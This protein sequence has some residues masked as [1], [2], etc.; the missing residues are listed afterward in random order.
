[1]RRLMLSLLL[2][3]LIEE[4]P[5]MDKLWV[6]F[7]ASYAMMGSANTSIAAPLSLAPAAMPAIFTVD[8]RYQSYNV[9]MAEVVGGNFWKPYDQKS[10]KKSEKKNS[11]VPEL[12][13]PTPTANPG[14][15]PLQISQGEMFQAR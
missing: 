6:M 4:V 15:A 5:A 10:E 12:K 11:A 3:S 7:A 8:A 14:R 9:E 1:M 2:R 13:S